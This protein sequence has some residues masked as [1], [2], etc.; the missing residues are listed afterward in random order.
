MRIGQHRERLEFVATTLDGGYDAIL[1]MPWLEFHD[2][3]VT[4][5]TQE[6]MLTLGRKRVVIRGGHPIGVHRAQQTAQIHQVS[7][8]VI[9]KDVQQEGTECFLFVIREKQ[10]VATPKAVVST[11]GPKDQRLQELLH[12]FS[13]VLVDGLPPGCRPNEPQTTE[14]NSFRE[15]TD[16][17][18]D[19][20]TKC[21]QPSCRKTKTNS[22]TPGQ[23][24][25]PTFSLALW[26][27]DI[28]CTQEGW[29]A[30][31]VY[32]LQGPQQSDQKK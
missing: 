10:E 2:P 30:T 25:H 21:H 24:L 9:Q 13:D 11:D 6:L 15:I 17:L 5:K 8:K 14:S 12:E 26:C 3:A 1:G 32:R 27:S 20:R 7:A 28:V 18:T 4:W 19:Q 22:G 29:L 16:R 23:R 31:H